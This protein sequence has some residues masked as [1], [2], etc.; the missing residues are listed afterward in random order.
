MRGERAQAG[1]QG[2][3][4]GGAGLDGAQGGLE[5][6]GLAGEAVGAEQGVGSVRCQ[7]DVGQG[8]VGVGPAQQDL[9]LLSPGR[10]GDQAQRGALTGWSAASTGAAITAMGG[11]VEGAA[12]TAPGQ[13]PVRE[14]LVDS[15]LAALGPGP[16]WMLLVGCGSWCRCGGW[17]QYP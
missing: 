2:A 6:A 3:G 16:P 10:L 8:S 17:D 9:S 14:L 5:L 15:E 12:L 7:E 11:L 13:V 4:A 1:E